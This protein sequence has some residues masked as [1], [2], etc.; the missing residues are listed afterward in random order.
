MAVI[1]ALTLSCSEI[2]LLPCLS[3]AE[4]QGCHNN[5]GDTRMTNDSH[6]A[7]QDLRTRATKLLQML[8]LLLATA[9]S[10]VQA[11]E[12]G[13]RLYIFDNGRIE[14]LAPELF[15]FTADEVQETSFIVT[16]YLIRHPQ[17]D[18]LWEA[19]AVPDEELPA[20]GSAYREGPTVVTKSLVSQLSAIGVGIE[21]IDYIAMSHLHSDHNGN[22]NTFAGAHWIVQEA[23]RTAMF[24]GEP[25]RVMDPALFSELQGADTTI[26][27]NED[28]D[29]FGD[30]TVRILSAPGHTPGHQ[31]LLLNLPDTGPVLLAGDLY[32]YPEE[33]TTGKTPTFEYD[34]PTTAVSRTH[35]QSVL[36]ETGAQL[37]IGHDLHTH[38]GLRFSPQW[39]E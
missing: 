24:S 30:G 19:G 36:E 33:I 39:Y 32:H 6:K 35:I 3:A 16:S 20:D 37:W 7:W 34:P 4:Q 17:G 21:D 31:V 5:P 29:V 38:E 14:G 23:E 26:L 8:A 28:Y 11:Q 9:G 2:E 18:L 25:F 22:A 13:L 1:L 10:H 12:P 15:N 27:H